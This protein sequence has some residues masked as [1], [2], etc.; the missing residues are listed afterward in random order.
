MPLLS[1][2]TV[3]SIDV[4]RSMIKPIKHTIL[5]KKRSHLSDS[6]GVDLFRASKNL[7]YSIMKARKQLARK[8]TD[9]L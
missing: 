8:I 9:S 2:C 6:K 7:R 5:T 4:E 1:M 3:G